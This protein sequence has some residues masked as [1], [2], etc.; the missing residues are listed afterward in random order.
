MLGPGCSDAFIATNAIFARTSTIHMSLEATSPD[1]F[2]NTPARF[3]WSLLMV[4]SDKYQTDALVAMVSNYGWQR[5][6]VL[7]TVYQ[8]G[9][10]GHR[11]LEEKLAL[12]ISS[13]HS[14]IAHRPLV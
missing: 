5:L 11:L 8:Y 4:P 12:Y 1:L 14:I 9:S 13:H 3:P 10:D 2:D 7:S 6:A